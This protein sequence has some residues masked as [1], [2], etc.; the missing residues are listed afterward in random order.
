MKKKKKVEP[1]A[2]LGRLV[3]PATVFRGRYRDEEGRKRGVRVARVDGDTEGAPSGRGRRG[4]EG[5]I[6]YGPLL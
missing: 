6:N 3:E 2:V 1:R 4:G 5:G